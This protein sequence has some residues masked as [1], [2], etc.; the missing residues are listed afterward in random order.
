MRATFAFPLILAALPF[1]AF[2]QDETPW[3]PPPAE[4]EMQNELP[5]GDAADGLGLIE[6]GAGMLLDNLLSD[7]GPELDQMGRDLSDGVREFAPMAR[8]LAAQVDDLRNYEAPKRL[9][10]GD[11]LIRRKAGAPPPRPSAPPRMTAPSRRK[12]R[13]LPIPTPPRSSCNRRMRHLAS[14]LPDAWP[15]FAWDFVLSCADHA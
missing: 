13:R 1:T 8:D 14:R 10:N 4:P 5:G 3:T 2:A 7:I 12:P 9:A 6:R 15:L 11:I